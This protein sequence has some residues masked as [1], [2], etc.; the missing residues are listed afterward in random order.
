M[1]KGSD[2]TWSPIFQHPD[3]TAAWSRLT[4]GLQARISAGTAAPN[5]L[6]SGPSQADEAF[7][8]LE[9]GTPM[10]LLQGPVCADG[11][12]FWKVTAGNSLGWTAEGDGSEYWLEPY[13]P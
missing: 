3:C 7:A 12:V 4:A 11:F 10:K 13:A 9:P 2:P 1:T 5:P 8:L 6:R